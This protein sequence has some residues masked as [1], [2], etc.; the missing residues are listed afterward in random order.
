MEAIRALT[1]ANKPVESEA[2]RL[3][4]ERSEVRALLADASRLSAATG[5][6]PRV[7]LDDGLARTVD[8]WRGRIARGL[9]RPSAAYAT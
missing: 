8:W 2:S 9:V 5:W 1:G 7:N 3:R 6:A 4:P